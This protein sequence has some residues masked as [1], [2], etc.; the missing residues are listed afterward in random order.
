MTPSL[1]RRPAAWIVLAA[2]SFL[3]LGFAVRY[4]PVAFPILTID[5]RMDRAQALKKG[6]ELALR[7]GL[8]PAATRE[9]AA[10]DSDDE[11][12]N[13]VELE[14]GGKE[15]FR[16]LIAGG[17]YAPYQWIVRRYHEG[18]ENEVRLYF[19]PDGTPYG[20]HEK[21]P[22]TRQ[23]AALPGDIALALAKTA[24]ARDWNVDFSVYGEP[25]A[26]HETRPSGRVDHTF[27][28]ERPKADQIGE[29]RFRL[30]LIVS[31]D[32]LT[33]VEHS[34][35]VPEAF[36]KRYEQMR[37]A[38]ETIS[39]AARYVTVLLYGV[40]GCLFGVF[41]LM[42]KRRVLWKAGLAAGAFVSFLQVLAALN[43]M[44]L[45]WM[46]YDTA[47]SRTNFVFAE[48]VQPLFDS[49]FLDALLFGASY[50]AA[51]SLTRRAF[52]HHLQFWKLWR[53]DV[54]ASPEVLGRTVGGYLIV[55]CDLAFVVVFY[56]VTGKYLGWWSPAETLVDPNL[57][58]NYLPWFNPLA[59]ALQAGTWEESLFRAVP[60]AGA[61]LIGTWIAEK[62][63]ASRIPWRTLCIGIAFVVQIVI[64]GAGHAFYPV[65][66]AYGRMVELIVPAALFGFLYLRYGLLPAMIA[67]FF[68]D[69]VMMS[70]ALMTSSLPGVWLDRLFFGLLV[71]LPLWVVLRARRRYPLGLLAADAWNKAWHPPDHAYPVPVPRTE[72]F[73]HPL[74]RRIV[75]LWHGLG[76]VGLALWAFS[77]LGGLQNVASR[78][79]VK[80][81]GA[82]LAARAELVR[83]GVALDPKEGWTLVSTVRAGNGDAGDFAWRA[84]KP[85]D[86]PI[87]E[88]YF[89][90]PPAWIVRFARFA[91]RIPVADR[92]EEYR[93][94][95]ARK[96]EVVAFE[97]ILPE[98][99]PGARLNEAEVRARAADALRARYGVDPTLLR[100]LVAD[101][102]RQP[103]R[104]DWR[105]VYAEPDLLRYPLKE[106]EGW[107]VVRVAG[108]EVRDVRGA[109]HVPDAWSRKEEDRRSP[110]AALGKI[111]GEMLRNGMVV[112]LVVAM[113]AWSQGRGGFVPSALVRFGV[114]VFVLKAVLLAVE[115]PSILAG[116]STSE[117]VRNQA[118]SAIGGQLVHIFFVALSI[119]V[120]AGYFESRHPLPRIDGAKPEL[121]R[122]I[123]AALGFACA[124]VGLRAVTGGIDSR[125]LT[126]PL[127]DYGPLAS[128]LPWFTAAAGRLIDILYTVAEVFWIL[129]LADYVRSLGTRS[130]RAARWSG[131]G[132]GLVI[133]VGT[134]AYLGSGGLGTF[135]EWA[136]T[137]I[138]S[139][140]LLWLAYVTFLRL[141]RAWL[142]FAFLLIGAFGLL[143]QGF[144]Y[145]WPGAWGWFAG[146][147]LFATVGWR[148]SKQM[149]K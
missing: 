41:I 7:F 143:K 86:Y 9:T 19:T 85:S 104:T 50:V 24:A 45:H 32:R 120:A 106:G 141:H 61:A 44:P 91:D 23:G 12:Q 147:L 84:G 148:W 149:T 76:L 47:L 117:P 138:A 99:R 66:P 43:Q 48:I 128:S 11:V 58:A 82:E 22:E 113:V 14:A 118:F 145:A 90:D 63:P 36:T 103:A 132:A 133:V 69:A 121:R 18:E 62:R 98:A 87:L 30:T 5:L 4:F 96:G 10:F 125:H 140:L 35:D 2:L 88:N 72:E 53:G 134:M 8:A 116:F 130:D 64:F 46:G 37:S 139:G 68:Y 94:R 100:P 93:L 122:A 59:E 20:F 38:N 108:T 74:R 136:L 34:V 111:L 15:A 124:W 97:H 13:Y 17:K 78:I 54:A 25:E 79:E 33:C 127:A 77:S 26:S 49:F 67:H 89:L 137:G 135:R 80:R 75:S 115:W 81:D 71:F 131:L 52:P 146:V 55:G 110:L 16:A 6:K 29:A 39:S 65:Q 51:E 70:L 21:I 144:L 126:P 102:K 57:P 95:V 42:R 40:G 114:G 83:R 142:P 3:C 60:L 101:A 92:V 123:L 119:G 28:F 109:I 31:G 27:V 1:F 105:L 112:G 107:Y 129:A 56:L 73:S